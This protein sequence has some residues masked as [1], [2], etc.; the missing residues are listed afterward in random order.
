MIYQSDIWAGL[1]CQAY[2]GNKN[3]ISQQEKNLKPPRAESTA[4]LQESQN[5]SQA[6]QELKMQSNQKIRKLTVKN[7]HLR[8]QLPMDQTKAIS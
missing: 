1:S 2:E 4:F 7:L 8:N 5:Q 6:Y 3:V